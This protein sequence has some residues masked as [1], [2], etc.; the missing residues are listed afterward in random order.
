MKIDALTLKCRFII[1]FMIKLWMISYL[2]NW[3][4]KKIHS[5]TNHIELQSKKK[6]MKMKKKR[7]EICK[8]SMKL[9]KN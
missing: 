1:L 4:N 8:E 7:E 6:E 2:I 3:K 5:V 9:S